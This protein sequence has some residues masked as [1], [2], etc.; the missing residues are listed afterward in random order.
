MKK[1]RAFR[2]KKVMEYFAAKAKAALSGTANDDAHKAYLL[3]KGKSADAED[4]VIKADEIKV[5]ADAAQTTANGVVTAAVK[6]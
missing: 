3:A 6:L 1:N 5:A 4:A 2:L